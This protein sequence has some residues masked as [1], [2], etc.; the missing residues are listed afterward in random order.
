MQF[1]AEGIYKARSERSKARQQKKLKFW[2]WRAFDS[3]EQMCFLFFFRRS[4][5][6]TLHKNFIFVSS[7]L[8][9]LY[10]FLHIGQPM[11]GLAVTKIIREHEMGKEMAE[12]QNKS[13]ISRILNVIYVHAILHCFQL[14]KSGQSSF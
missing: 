2:P 4:Q 10:A 14:M 5:K 8:I 7:F 9:S 13:N 6:R 1:F 12:K 11:V 3:L